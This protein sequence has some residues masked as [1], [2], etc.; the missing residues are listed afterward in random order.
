MSDAAINNSMEKWDPIIQIKSGTMNVLW[1]NIYTCN[2]DVL[3]RNSSRLNSSFRAA[4]T[5]WGAREWGAG[6]EMQSLWLLGWYWFYQLI[7][8]V[9]CNTLIMYLFFLY[10]YKKKFKKLSQKIRKPKEFIGRNWWGIH[11]LVVTENN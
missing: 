3:L 1:R 5:F 9:C 10:I 6:R 4:I 8:K 11:L 7:F 2:K